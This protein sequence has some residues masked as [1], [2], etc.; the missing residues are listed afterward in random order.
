MQSESNNFAA[1]ATTASSQRSLHL[2]YKK[3]SL[4]MTPPT[5]QDTMRLVF[6]LRCDCSLWGSRPR[7][8]YAKLQ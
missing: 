7:L 3:P 1:L 5:L 2:S 8:V 6:I 4:S